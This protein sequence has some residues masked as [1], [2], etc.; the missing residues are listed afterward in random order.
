MQAIKKCSL[1]LFLS[2]CHIGAGNAQTSAPESIPKIWGEILLDEQRCQSLTG[3]FEYF[4]EEGRSEKYIKL[5]RLDMLGFFQPLASRNP[6]RVTLDHD[7][8]SGKITITVEHEGGVLKRGEAVV[9]CRGGWNEIVRQS[10]AANGES[11]DAVSYETSK[12]TRTDDGALVIQFNYEIVT[13]FLLSSTRRKG[14]EWYR[15]LPG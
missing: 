6:K 8:K 5:P 9:S 1:L 12:L 10:K 11:A 7:L 13:R 4:G 2:I 14:V 15:F 3:S